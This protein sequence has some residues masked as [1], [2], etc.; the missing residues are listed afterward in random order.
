ML[1]NLIKTVL[2]AA[3]TV[4]FASVAMADGKPKGGKKLAGKEMM[5]IFAGKTHEWSSGGGRYYDADGSFQQVNSS[6]SVNFGTYAPTNKGY[7]C[8]NSKTVIEGYI[9]PNPNPKGD[10]CMWML[11]TKDGAVWINMDGHKPNSERKDDWW[12]IVNT[13]GSMTDSLKKGNKIQ[14]GF[15]SA[16]KKNGPDAR[17]VKA[18]AGMKPITTK[19][20]FA[21]MVVGKNLVQSGKNKTFYSADGT[22][23][24]TF[25]GQSYKA[26]WKWKRDKLCR[27]AKGRKEDCQVWKGDGKHFKAVNSMGGYWYLTLK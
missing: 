23:T 2:A 17:A 22:Q 20:Q 1:N 27:K 26:T 18:E 15:K 25:R 5:A 24:G 19:D 9:G 13:D 6:G 3:V 7:V 11:R 14:S 10:N 21:A 12:R 8:L 4:S 16:Y